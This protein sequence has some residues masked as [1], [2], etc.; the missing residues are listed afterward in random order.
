MAT[1]DVP[2][3]RRFLMQTDALLKEAAQNEENLNPHV[4]DYFITRLKVVDTALTRMML[5]CHFVDDH[6]STL[7]SIIY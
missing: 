5:T 3:L 7:V 2:D 6:S 1:S 4:I